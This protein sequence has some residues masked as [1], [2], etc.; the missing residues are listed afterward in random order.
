MIHIPYEL[1]T[2][3]QADRQRKAQHHRLV[4]TT[5]AERGHHSIKPTSVVARFVRGLI[6]KA[7]AVPEAATRVSSTAQ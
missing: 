5:T 2:A 6:Q 3:V 1:G 7:P 4:Q